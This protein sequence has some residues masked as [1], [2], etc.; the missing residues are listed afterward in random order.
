M[1]IEQVQ[2]TFTHQIMTGITG[3]TIIQN[4]MTADMVTL[5]MAIMMPMVTGITMIGI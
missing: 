1:D 2:S 5:T 4:G 3:T